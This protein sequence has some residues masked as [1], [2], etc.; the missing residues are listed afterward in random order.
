MENFSGK[1]V[2]I[3]GGSSGIGFAVAKLLSRE[4]ANIALFARNKTRL[5]ESLITIEQVKR[6][7]GQR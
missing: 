2:F 7:H 5:A 6:R 3:T 4:G 1:T